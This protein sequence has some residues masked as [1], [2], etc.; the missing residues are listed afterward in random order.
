G[1]ALAGE[2]DRGLHA[3]DIGGG[4]RP[5][6]GD[7]RDGV[8]LLRWCGGFGGGL[9]GFGIFGFGILGLGILGL[10]ILG[11]GVLGFGI[12]GLRVLGFGVLAFLRLGVDFGFCGLGVL[13]LRVLGCGDGRSLGVGHCPKCQQP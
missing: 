11:L 12:F 8:G 7:R 9:A 10:G 13:G 6:V 1:L 5:G 3:R 2:G 4:G